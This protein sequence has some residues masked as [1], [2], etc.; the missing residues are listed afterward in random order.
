[1][2]TEK[3]KKKDKTDLTSAETLATSKWKANKES[4][5]GRTEEKKK[6]VKTQREEDANRRAKASDQEYG[7]VAGPAEGL[8][9]RKPKKNGSIDGQKNPRKKRA[10]WE[11]WC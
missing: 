2:S 8:G 6:E 1:L 11:R 10:G 4:K 5:P 7:L 9:A 3:R